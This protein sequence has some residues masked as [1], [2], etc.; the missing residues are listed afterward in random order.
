MLGMWLALA[1]ENKYMNFKEKKENPHKRQ[2]WFMPGKH[3]PNKKHKWK[4]DLL[5][6]CV[7]MSGR[8]SC[9]DV[10]EVFKGASHTGPENSRAPTSWSTSGFSRCK[11]QW[12]S[13]QGRCAEVE[14]QCQLQLP[15]SCFLLGLSA[16][17][18]HPVFPVCPFVFS[19]SPPAHGS[20]NLLCK[21]WCSCRLW[22]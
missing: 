14:P 3:T 13:R 1:W 2:I 5:L 4:H 18:V 9:W 6:W 11:E 19:P 16:F 7:G 17:C 15:P 21:I 12:W 10:E 20:Q 22:S 8:A